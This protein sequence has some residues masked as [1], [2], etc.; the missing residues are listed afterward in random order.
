[1]TTTYTLSL[2]QQRTTP[3]RRRGV[4]ASVTSAIDAAWRRG[5]G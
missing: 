3:D 5:E 2:V 1:M 4:V